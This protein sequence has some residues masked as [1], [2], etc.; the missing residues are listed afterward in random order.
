[1]L[2]FYYRDSLEFLASF[3]FQNILCGNLDFL[4]SARVNTI[5]FRSFLHVESAEA[6]QSDFVTTLQGLFGDFGKSV[7]SF[8]GVNFGHAGFL[9][10]CCD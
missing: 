8:S 5:A 4:A 6:D 9:G 7:E 2:F 10:N 3:E 1:M